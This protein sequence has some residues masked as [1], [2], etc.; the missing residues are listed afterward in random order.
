MRRLRQT[1]S[2]HV[3]VVRDAGGLGEALQVFAGL[4]AE[5]RDPQLKNALVAARMITVAA[6]TR[7]ES[8]GG[9]QRSD[10]PQSDPALARRNFTTLAQCNQIAAEAVRPTLVAHA[11]A[12]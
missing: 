12:A 10:F 9:H 4:E 5:A 1:M 8:R 3:G 11:P 2:R 7:E 6:L